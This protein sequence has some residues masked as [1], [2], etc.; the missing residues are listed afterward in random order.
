MS[1]LESYMKSN[2]EVITVA[3]LAER[4]VPERAVSSLETYMGG[5]VPSSGIVKDIDFLKA[6]LKESRFDLGHHIRLW[7]PT[8]AFDNKYIT[9]EQS[10]D[11]PE[12]TVIR[13]KGVVKPSNV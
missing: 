9:I 3:E 10:A 2:E 6:E 7:A 5:K 8:Q 12:T 11:D 4:F 1:G 13:I